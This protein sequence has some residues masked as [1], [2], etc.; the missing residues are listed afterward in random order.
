MMRQAVGV[1]AP[2]L[3]LLTCMEAAIPFHVAS[4]DFFQSLVGVPI[5]PWKLTRAAKDANRRLKAFMTECLTN[6][7]AAT[8]TADEWL[9]GTG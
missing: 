7:K 6:V 5:S 8:V 2:D 1:S 9:G 4:S 3:A